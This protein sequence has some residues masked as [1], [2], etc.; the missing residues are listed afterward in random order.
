MQTCPSNAI[1]EEMV[2]GV[3]HKNQNIHKITVIKE[4]TNSASTKYLARVALAF[5]LN[6]RQHPHGMESEA[7]YFSVD[8]LR[9][10]QCLRKQVPIW[11]MKINEGNPKTRA[12]EL[13]NFG[14][15]SEDM[16]ENSDGKD[17]VRKYSP[18]KN[19]IL[20]VLVICN[21]RQA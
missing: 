15:S 17:M 1:A 5:L 4:K 2:M 14:I 7:Q 21:L 3:L 8:S 19:K 20:I 13:P 18:G 10:R 6:H 9:T 16:R 11:R 12:E